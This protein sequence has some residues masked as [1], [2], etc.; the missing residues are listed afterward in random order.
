MK[1]TKRQLRRIIKEEK[2]KLSEQPQATAHG[3]GRQ[4]GR[5]ESGDPQSY[6]ELASRMDQLTSQLED[7]TM[8]Y[9]DSGWLKDGDHNSLAIDLDKLFQASDRLSMALYG[10]AKSNGEM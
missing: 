2:T 4:Y 1:I 9:V 3:R 6:G 8:D 5:S 7:L 10:L